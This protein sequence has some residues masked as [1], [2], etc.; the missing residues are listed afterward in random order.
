MAETSNKVLQSRLEIFKS[1]FDSQLKS[2]DEAISLATEK[3]KAA[4]KIID[5]LD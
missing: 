2:A 4:G 3:A 5:K 1:K